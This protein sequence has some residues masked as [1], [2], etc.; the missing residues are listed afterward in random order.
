MD[1]FNITGSDAGAGTGSIVTSA[2]AQ[3]D[4]LM[5]FVISPNTKTTFFNLTLEVEA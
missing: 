1:F 4:I 2:I 3:G 5:P